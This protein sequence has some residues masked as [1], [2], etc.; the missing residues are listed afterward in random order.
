MPSSIDD[1]V[2]RNALREALVALVA[3][4]VCAGYSLTYCY[5]AA[6]GLEAERVQVVWG[7]PRW[8]VVGILLPWAAALVF[9][10]WYCFRCIRDDELSPRPEAEDG[11]QQATRQREE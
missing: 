11:A 2:Y 6:Y 5:Y 3:W 4:A 10:W 8:I 9:A 7:I 1:P